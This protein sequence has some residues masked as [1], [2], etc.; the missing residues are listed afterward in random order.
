MTSTKDALATKIAT[1]WYGHEVADAIVQGHYGLSNAIQGLKL[2]YS[3]S[4]QELTDFKVDEQR[5]RQLDD[6]LEGFK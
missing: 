1:E 6:L 5:R 3:L 4:E 2:Q